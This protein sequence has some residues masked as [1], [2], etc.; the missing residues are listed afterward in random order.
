L[1]KKKDPRHS[2]SNWAAFKSKNHKFFLSP[3]GR[4]NFRLSPRSKKNKKNKQENVYPCNIHGKKRCYS[5]PTFE[6]L[7]T[8]KKNIKKNGTE[9]SLTNL[10]FPSSDESVTSKNE[11]S[12]VHLSKDDMSYS[13]RA[14]KCSNSK[15]VDIF[16]YGE[17]MPQKNTDCS[18]FIEVMNK[19][20]SCRESNTDI[21]YEDSVI[22]EPSSLLPSPEITDNMSKTKTGIGNDTTKTDLGID[23]TR[24]EIRNGE[25]K[26]CWTIKHITGILFPRTKKKKEPTIKLQSIVE[27]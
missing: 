3:K 22:F 11:N 18:K 19:E 12:S 7:A 14:Q 9:Y 5:K 24:T 25:K 15:S 17:V 4:S 27:E 16:R 20:L 2:L 26:K 23:P 6:Y 21:L 13:T 1:E 10:L 8:Y